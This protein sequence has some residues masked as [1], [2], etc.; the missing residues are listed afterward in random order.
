[1]QKDV[2]ASVMTGLKTLK[3]RKSAQVKGPL[4]KSETGETGMVGEIP[5]N[6]SENRYHVGHLEG[7]I[8]RTGRELNPKPQTLVTREHGDNAPAAA[9]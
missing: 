1:M 6:R 5:D 4:A 7:K 9:H 2:Y 8:D 3:F